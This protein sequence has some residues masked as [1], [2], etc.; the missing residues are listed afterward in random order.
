MIP[1]LEVSM[2]P[3]RATHASPTTIDN[4]FSMSPPKAD[5]FSPVGLLTSTQGIFMQ[6]HHNSKYSKAIGLL[7]APLTV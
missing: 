2:H 5:E 3:V 4:L 1:I 6:L 7:V